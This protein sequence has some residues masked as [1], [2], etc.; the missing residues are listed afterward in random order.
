MNKRQNMCKIIL[1]R[2]FSTIC[3]L[4]FLVSCDI[5]QSQPDNSYQT[6]TTSIKT[7]PSLT[8][9]II[10]TP[11]L[12]PTKTATPIPTPTYSPEEIKVRIEE[13]LETNGGCDLPC[14]WGLIPG[15]TNYEDAIR[16]FRDLSL[17]NNYYGN[18][19]N[20]FSTSIRVPNYI[21]EQGL[22]Y[23][24]MMR[25]NTENDKIFA[26]AVGGYYYPMTELL[27]MFGKPAEIY[28]S[29]QEQFPTNSVSFSLIL[30]YPS[31]GILV[32]IFSTTIT[33]NPIN[34]IQI[35][36]LETQLNPRDLIAFT[37]WNPRNELTFDEV[38]SLPVW[39]NPPSYSSIDTISN[40]DARLFFQNFG[41][42]NPECLVVNT[43]LYSSHS[44]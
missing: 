24:N 1:I 31:K 5:K 4:L 30:F 40:M 15:E 8:P 17:S 39:S 16:F 43:A 35:C 20:I 29:S 27:G 12:I 19:E 13:L 9:S 10:S 33:P 18:S 28:F 21:N 23:F 44:K 32:F 38:I 34:E 22:L 6:Q 2:F 36:D 3:V 37:F 7:S 26:D 11:L 42:P 14:W 25:E 41:S